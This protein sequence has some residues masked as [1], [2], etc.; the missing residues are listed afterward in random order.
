[1]NRLRILRLSALTGFRDY[2]TIYTWRTWLV[3]WYVRVLA[4]VVF[5]AL[6]GKLLGSEE[7]VRYL[8]IGNSVMLAAIGSL[9]AVAGTTWERRAGTLPLLVASPTSPTLVFTGRS[10]WAL[11][12]GIASSIGVFYVAAAVFGVPLAWPRALLYVP[13]VV[14]IGLSCYALGTFLGGLVLRAMGLRNVVANI[15]WGTMLAFCGATVPLSFYPEAVQWVAH[16]LPLT[17]GLEA[18]RGAL[19]NGSAA[20]ILAEAALEALVG[21]VWLAL[22]LLTFERLAE[23]GRRDG[24]I[25]FAS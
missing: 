8:L 1:V 24:S 4:Q 11:T 20:S 16:A 18:V 19:G 15:V 17:H 6:I 21:L 7:R 9:F 3:G 23:G 10:A 25:E 14:L 12:E 5:F 13:L 22:A 2:A